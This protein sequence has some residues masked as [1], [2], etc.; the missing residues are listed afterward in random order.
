MI[1]AWAM[2]Q[3]SLSKFWLVLLLLYHYWCSSAVVP[4]ATP[5]KA[6]T[7]EICSDLDEVGSVVTLRHTASVFL[8]IPCIIW[9][10][11]EFLFVFIKTS[12]QSCHSQAKRMLVNI[13]EIGERDLL[14]TELSQCKGGWAIW[15][16]SCEERLKIM[17]F[18]ISRSWL[19]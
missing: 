15:L 16:F 6:F 17:V 10:S 9:V 8:S 13:K 1:I 11:G 19:P 14:H 18:Y 2:C 7:S 4:N 5:L 12:L 3:E